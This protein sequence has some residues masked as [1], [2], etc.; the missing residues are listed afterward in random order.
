MKAKFTFEILNHFLRNANVLQRTNLLHS[1]VYLLKHYLLFNMFRTSL[2]IPGIDSACKIKMSFLICVIFSKGL[3]EN[4]T[5]K[6]NVN[7]TCY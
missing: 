3:S 1:F 4:I 7:Q 6:E 5:F 2:E